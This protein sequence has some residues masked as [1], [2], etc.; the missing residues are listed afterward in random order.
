LNLSSNC[1]SSV[2]PEEELY[3]LQSLEELSLD[4][5]DLVQFVQ[6]RA[7]D[8]LPRLRKLSLASNRIK[9]LKDDAPDQPGDPISY[10]ESL[11][12]LDL[13][14]NEIVRVDELP[15]VKL[16]RSLRKLTLSDN[17]C[18]KTTGASEQT[19]QRMKFFYTGYKAVVPLGV[20]VLQEAGE[21]YRAEAKD[22]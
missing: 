14:G 6:W 4:A 11:E 15:A 21:T 20:W 18:T 5:N 13:S 16:F 3:G 22:G 10:F 1:I 2:P 17:P 7:L 19:T 12:E 8:V 9:R